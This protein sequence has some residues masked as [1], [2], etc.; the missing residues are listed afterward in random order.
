M[1]PSDIVLEFHMHT[2]VPSRIQLLLNDTDSAVFN[3]ALFTETRS[4]RH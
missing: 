1:L 2:E 3:H 4:F